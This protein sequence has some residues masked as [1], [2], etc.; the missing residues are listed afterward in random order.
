MPTFF[1]KDKSLIEIDMKTIFIK[2]EQAFL[3]MLSAIEKV[4]PDDIN[5]EKFEEAKQNFKN[6]L[7]S[8]RQQIEEIEEQE[9]EVNSAPLVRRN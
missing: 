6:Y 2:T 7:E 9:F 5:K 8:I 1:K 3:C 4:K